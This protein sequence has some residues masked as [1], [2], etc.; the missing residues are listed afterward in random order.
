MAYPPF[1][2]YQN[3]PTLEKVIRELDIMSQSAR[4]PMR[5]WD[6]YDRVR[7]HLR[8]IQDKFDIVYQHQ[9]IKDDRFHLYLEN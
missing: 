1:I 6:P 3:W 5:Y 8:A 2:T 4:E 9:T 7:E